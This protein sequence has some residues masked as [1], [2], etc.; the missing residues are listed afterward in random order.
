VAA[1]EV[2]LH[3]KWLESI[4]HTA[5]PIPVAVVQAIGKH[6]AEG[7]LRAV[8]GAGSDGADRP[9]RVLTHCNTGALATAA[10]G[11]ALGVVRSL[12]EQGKL[13]RTYC[14]ETRPYNQGMLHCRLSVLL[15]LLCQST[16]IISAARV[17]AEPISYSQGP[18]PCRH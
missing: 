1:V 8:A 7:M 13:E 17:I 18:V 15:Q 16:S 5:Q 11:T 9:L 4:L 3:D 12:G 14:T 10:Y 6:G 2:V